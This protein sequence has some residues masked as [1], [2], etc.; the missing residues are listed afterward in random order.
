MKSGIIKINRNFLI[1]GVIICLF[2][3]YSLVVI[4]FTLIND[5]FGRNISNIFLADKGDI[6]KYFSEKT[7][8]IPFATVKLFVNAYKKGSLETYVVIE[9]ILG[10]LFAFMPFAFFIPQT[11]KKVKGVVKFF[12]VILICVLAIEFLQVLFLTGSA[13]VDDVILN[14]GGALLAYAVLNIKVIKQKI[15]KFLLGD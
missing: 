3:L 12:K 7:N 2:F 5:T 10:N 13:D 4:D 15:N 6:I 1:K 8:I 11:F 14:V 9:N